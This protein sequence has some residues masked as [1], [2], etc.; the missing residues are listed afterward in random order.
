MAVAKPIKRENGRTKQFLS[1]DTVPFSNIP[2]GKVS[3]TIAT[4]DDNRFYDDALLIEQALG[5]AVL[6]QTMPMRQISATATPVSGTVYFTAIYYRPVGSGIYRCEM[7]SINQ[8]KL[9]CKQ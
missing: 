3:N 5:S 6:A 4:G 2:T 7:A 1:T 8:R 9:C